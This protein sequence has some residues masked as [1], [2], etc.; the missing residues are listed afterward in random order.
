MNLPTLEKLREI[1]DKEFRKVYTKNLKKWKNNMTK[2][3][4]AVKRNLMF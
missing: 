4:I 3:N 2:K 1:E